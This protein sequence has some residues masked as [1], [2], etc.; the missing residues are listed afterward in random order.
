MIRTLVFSAAFLAAAVSLHAQELSDAEKKDGFR[1]LFDGKSFDGWK[2]SDKTPKSWK[3]EDGLLRLTGGGSHL[4]TNDTFED[5]ILRLE[6]RPA[7]KGYNSGLFIRGNNQIQML[8]SDCGHLMSNAKETKGVPNLHKAPGEWNEWE[9]VCIGS[10]IGLKVNG[11]QA[12][13]IDTFKAKKGPIGIE[14]EGHAIDFK[15][16]RIKVLKKD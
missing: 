5:F 6:W 10:K 16:L 14:A 2:T 8:Q 1:L 13:E 12:W 15:N 7:K 9:V 11:T 4:F 3:I